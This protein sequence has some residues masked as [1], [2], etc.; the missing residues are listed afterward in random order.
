M[1]IAG[2]LYDVPGISGHALSFGRVAL[3]G[4]EKK[5][6]NLQVAL[7]DYDDVHRTAR[8]RGAAVDPWLRHRS[9]QRLREGRSSRG[10]ATLAD[11]AE[12]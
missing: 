9:R 8:A 4:E 5:S 3:R 1:S 11:A 10:N 6:K 2:E 7:R 12:S